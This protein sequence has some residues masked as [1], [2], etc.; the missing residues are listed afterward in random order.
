M[1][2]LALIFNFSIVF[3]GIG[4]PTDSTHTVP[5]TVELSDSIEIIRVDSL[6]AL[7]TKPG[8]SLTNSTLVLPVSRYDSLLHAWQEQKAML[9]YEQFFSD[10]INID[11]NIVYASSI[12]DSVYEARLQMILSPIPLVF[13]DIVKRYII[14][15]TTTRRSTMSQILG[16]SQYFFPI[17]EPELD[18]AG[19]PLEL[20][21]LPVIESALSPTARSRA[22][23]TGL[24]QFMYGT[25]KSYGLEISSF[26]DQRIDPILS[27]QAACRYLKDLYQIY[28]DWLLTLAAYNCGPGNV[29]KAIARAGGNTKNFWELYPYLP[30][31]TRGY[32][33][34][35]IAATYAYTFHQY[36][37]IEP[38][39][40]SLPIA[41][42]TLTINR[43]LH[44]DQISSTID[45]PTDL[46][47]DLNPQY[48]LDIIPALGKNYILTLPTNDIQE[49]LQHEQEILA[50]DTTYL[51]QYLKPSNIDKNKKVFS[52]DSYTYVVKKGDTLGAIA[53][54]NHVTVSQLMRW[55][56]LKNA[57]R[58]RIGQRLEIFR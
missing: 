8:D 28:G 2:I 24:W 23:A 21:M 56:N 20:R 14:A 38:A 9:I 25:G 50:K 33:P 1:N 29:N 10:F 36:H 6:S 35:F 57:H 16:R 43:L 22:G 30:R 48:K 40:I 13:N 32:I 55:N 46:L 54:R 39:R 7:S 12:P 18:R 49:Y 3:S 27:T 26:V 37:D 53:Q 42:D 51:A 31:E 11:T 44:F 41:T 17:I 47:R 45:I 19:L 4:E 58:L 5:T 34:S 52:I 15:Y